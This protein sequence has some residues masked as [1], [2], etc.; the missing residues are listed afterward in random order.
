MQTIA[1]CMAL[2]FVLGTVMASPRHSF[3]GSKR[4]Q[5]QGVHRK[6]QQ[7]L[8]LR[9]RMRKM[10]KLLGLRRKMRQAK[11][12]PKAEPKKPVKRKK[13]SDL[14][15][16][17]LM[18]LLEGASGY[19]DYIRRLTSE[20]EPDSGGAFFALHGDET[21][22]PE[23]PQV[24][25]KLGNAV[26]AY[27]PQ[28]YTEVFW[29]AGE[30]TIHFQIVEEADGQ[31]VIN[32]HKFATS[33]KVDQDDEF[34]MT[35]GQVRKMH[36]ADLV[37]KSNKYA[38]KGCKRCHYKIRRRMVESDNHGR[39]FQFDR[40]WRF[41]NSG[42]KKMI[43]GQLDRLF[44]R[45]KHGPTKKNPLYRWFWEQKSVKRRG[46]KIRPKDTFAYDPFVRDI[47]DLN[48]HELLGELRREKHWHKY[49]RAFAAAV[50]DSRRVD[51]HLRR[52]LGMTRV[53]L[54]AERERIERLHAETNLEHQRS[55]NNENMAWILAKGKRADVKRYETNEMLLLNK[56]SIRTIGPRILDMVVSEDEWRGLSDAERKRKVRLSDLDVRS[57]RE[58]RRIVSRRKVVATVR[59]RTNAHI[60]LQRLLDTR[61]PKA[62]LQYLSSNV[63]AL[64]AETGNRRYDILDAYAK[65]LLNPRD[66]ALNEREVI[67]AR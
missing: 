48:G 45:F 42:D 34:R 11:I 46:G 37:K 30:E 53:E 6:R 10:R 9:R 13:G 41:R 66:S 44:K 63:F 43:R 60:V 67:D 56:H 29:S 26:I 59:R 61:N 40:N 25:A 57:M 58:L 35:P 17:G 8:R 33:G 7:Q 22:T 23:T 4:G 39:R 15:L 5:S 65:G 24:F 21:V 54:D 47:L 18:D 49:K 36:R 31:L 14:T 64:T 28:M 50:Q 27:A 2:L 51:D 38:K 32:G 3:A 62:P 55:R 1:R 16:D 19:A 12:R 20:Y 52:D